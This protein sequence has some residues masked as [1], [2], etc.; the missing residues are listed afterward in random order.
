MVIIECHIVPHGTCQCQVSALKNCNDTN[1]FFFFM[2]NEF[3]GGRGG[4][5]GS[6]REC[7]CLVFCGTYKHVLGDADVWCSV[8]LRGGRH[9]S[10]RRKLTLD[11]QLLSLPHVLTPGNQLIQISS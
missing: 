9:Q 2:L 7:K 4:G 6:G 10:S 1:C 5:M 3:V 8:V 11:G